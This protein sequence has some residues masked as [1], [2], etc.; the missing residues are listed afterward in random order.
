ME[1]K[2]VDIPNFISVFSSWKCMYACHGCFQ[3]WPSQWKHTLKD[4][5]LFMPLS[6]FKLI[7]DE[8]SSFRTKIGLYSPAENFLNPDIYDMISYAEKAGCPVECD[9]TGAPVDPVRLAETNIHDIIFSIDG[10][11]QEAYGRFRRNGNLQNVLDRLVKFTQ[12]IERL[13]TK[14]NIVVKYLVNAF[15]ESQ[16]DEARAFYESLPGVT[17]KLDF[18]LP[19]TPFEWF[20]KNRLECSIEEYELWRPKFMTDFDIYFPVAE[21]GVAVHKVMQNSEIGPFCDN[22]L[23]GLTIDTDGT[24]MPCC[25]FDFESREDNFYFGNIFDGGGALPVF[26]GE[27]ARRFR[28]EYYAQG[29][30]CGRCSSC[31]HNMS[32]REREPMQEIV[33]R[34]DFKT[35]ITGIRAS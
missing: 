16:I 8:F 3:S 28:E 7:V 23:L 26:H 33:R 25:K 29:G 19:P 17:F 30:N 21:R 1:V 32:V 18:F 20:H 22:V 15:T 2:A 6:S 35:M 5:P 11:T 14:T 13:G 9:T 34:H 12:E 4:K 27:R 31:P 10:F 24:V